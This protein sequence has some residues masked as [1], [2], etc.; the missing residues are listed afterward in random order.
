MSKKSF[1]EYLLFPYYC[2]QLAV[3]TCKLHFS[4][5][6]HPENTENEDYDAEEDEKY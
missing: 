4:K 2:I 6:R 5:P 3:I 1:W